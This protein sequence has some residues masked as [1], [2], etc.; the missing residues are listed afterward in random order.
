M[1]PV[2][3]LLTMS[4]DGFIADVDDGVEWLCAPPEDPP[5]DYLELLD[6]IDC[7]VMGAGTYLV[8]LDLVGGT[9]I[10]E[11]KEVYVFT[12]RTDLPARRGVTFVHEPAEEFVRTLR[13]REGGTIWLFG[14]GKL[15]TGLSDAGLVDDYFIVV[16]PI[17]L[18]DGVP[19][20]RTPHGRTQLELTSA[21]AWPG[22]LAELRFRPRSML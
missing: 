20:W 12:S 8:S 21:K 22:G 4:L 5:S 13:Q 3:L 14:G 18:G 9:D 11:G 19:L 6:T 1:R 7:L 10:F 17:L 16:Q 15:A 2:L